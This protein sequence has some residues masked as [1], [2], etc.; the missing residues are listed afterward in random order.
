MPQDLAAF[1]VSKAEV[2]VD[3]EDSAQFR[4]QPPETAVDLIPRGQIATVADVPGRIKG[5]DVHLE[6]RRRRWDVAAR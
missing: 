4:R 6:A 2:V 5:L 3:D 1:R